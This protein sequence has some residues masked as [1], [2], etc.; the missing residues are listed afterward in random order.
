[1]TSGSPGSKQAR[2]E[3]LV[4]SGEA[5]L[6]F[7][8]EKIDRLGTRELFSGRP[9]PGGDLDTG[10]LIADL[11]RPSA[12]GVQ[13]YR[14]Q[15]ASAGRDGVACEA[16]GNGVQIGEIC[17]VVA[18]FRFPRGVGEK[19]AGDIVL[20]G[21]HGRDRLG[22]NKRR[23]QFG[24]GLGGDCAARA[25]RWIIRTGH[26]NQPQDANHQDPRRTPRHS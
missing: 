16:L 3:V 8:L 24:R 6:A 2:R 25:I 4:N 14:L 23:S 21:L 9:V 5:V 13:R 15:Q 1:M 18:G 10:Q 11:D 19:P 7:A 20:A 22:G 12:V 17:P 26:R